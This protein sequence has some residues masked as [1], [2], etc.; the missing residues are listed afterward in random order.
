MN[1]LSIVL[2]NSS[3]INDVTNMAKALSLNSFN[4]DQLYSINLIRILIRVVLSQIYFVINL[5]KSSI[6]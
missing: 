4:K 3:N 5:I 6:I 1:I 2:L